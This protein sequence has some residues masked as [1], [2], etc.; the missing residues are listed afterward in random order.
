MAVLCS[1]DKFANTWLHVVGEPKANKFYYP[2]D[3]VIG[4]ELAV[5][6]KK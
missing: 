4:W 6:E 1:V 3:T 5:I 2:T